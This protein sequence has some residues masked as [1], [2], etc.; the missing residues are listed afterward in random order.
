MSVE[1]RPDGRVKK[2]EWLRVKLPTGKNI[3]N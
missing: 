1:L 3:E 2:P